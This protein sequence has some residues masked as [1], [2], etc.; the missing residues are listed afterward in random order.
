MM[1][2][3][4]IGERHV[5]A[6]EKAGFCHWAEIRALSVEDVIQRVNDHLCYVEFNGPLDQMALENL[7]SHDQPISR[8]YP[9]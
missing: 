9:R 1:Q 7:I 8:P 4:M 5:H 6:L 3:P 2:V